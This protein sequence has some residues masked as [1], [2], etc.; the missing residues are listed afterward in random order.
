MNSGEFFI[1]AKNASVASA[2]PTYSVA[3]LLLKNIQFGRAGG[4]LAT[5]VVRT[6]VTGGVVPSIL[7]SCTAGETIAIPYKAQYLFFK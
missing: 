3:S 6:D 1:G 4:D 2:N 7:S 5:W